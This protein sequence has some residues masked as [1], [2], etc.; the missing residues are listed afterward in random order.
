MR[1][2]DDNF[3]LLENG[4]LVITNQHKL[5]SP[6]NFC[7]ES[8]DIVED[9]N[10]TTTAFVCVPVPANNNSNV[11]LIIYVTCEYYLHYAVIVFTYFYKI[12]TKRF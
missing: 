7:F 8:V 11:F 10:W 2:E 12:Y 9:G 6:N 4:S 3:Y 5:L 1:P